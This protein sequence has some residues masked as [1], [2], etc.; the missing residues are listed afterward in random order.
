[1][2]ILRRWRSLIACVLIAGLAAG[3][4]SRPV[5]V[6]IPVPDTVAGTGRVNMVVATVR[7]RVDTPDIFSGERGWN[8][9]YA[10]VTVSIPPDG[11]RKVGDVQWP[12][13]VPGNPATDFV[14]TKL[15]EL[16]Q[17]QAVS[18]FHD[19]IKKTPGRQ[20]LVFVHGF[21]QRFDDAVFRFA[22]IV[23]DSGADVT[24][25]LF[26]W[27]SR[28]S[29]LAYGYD[30][31]STSYSRDS[32]ER[33]LTFMAKDP[34][35]G[36]I[37]ILAHSMGNVVTLEALR[38]M[39][40]RNGRILP[41]IKY[42]MLAAPDVDVDVFHT[43]LRELGE[44]RP[45]FTLFVSQDD[46]ALAVSKRVWGDV[47][48]IG[49][50]NPEVEPYRTEFERYK[51]NVLDL[52]KLKTDD[53]LAHGKFAASPQ[54]VQAI[55]ARLAE[56]QT[57]TDSRVGVGEHIV[58]FTTNAAS[59]VGQAA[60]LVIAAPVAVVDPTTRENYGRHMENLG[61]VASDTASSGKHVMTTA[62]GQ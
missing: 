8:P 44:P 62:P 12:R 56:G 26:T 27:P 60:G 59:T 3:C 39:A 21:N 23:H 42:V 43:I 31:E 9:S 30:R 50:V 28:G 34:N 47:P 20:A 38:Q 41:K 53:P 45:Q 58:E 2:R 61:N 33:L 15:D 57:M 1:M 7:K 16:T 52:T 5:G 40:I 25:V 10:E 54:V 6:L 13:S 46:K 11:A 35:V 18:W 24:P 19:R 51:I 4:A 36:E 29:L 49:Q 22:Q 37:S 55:G 17:A 14:T 32:L 48:R